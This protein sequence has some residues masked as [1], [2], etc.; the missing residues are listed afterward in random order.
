MTSESCKWE[1][2]MLA[3]FQLDST[4][5]CKA[6]NREN[7]NTICLFYLKIKTWFSYKKWQITLL[8]GF[9]IQTAIWNQ[10]KTKKKMET[11]DNDEFVVWRGFYLCGSSLEVHVLN[12]FNPTIII[13][14]KK[15]TE[16]K[17]LDEAKTEKARGNGLSGKR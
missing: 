14:Q 3:N 5:N 9:F 17:K 7:D 16:G 2:Y 8:Y 10:M 1:L 11:W 12:Q 4:R 15:R 13:C 6:W